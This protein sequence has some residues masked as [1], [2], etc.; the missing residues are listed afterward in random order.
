MAYRL[1]HNPGCS[2][3]RASLALLNDSGVDYEL[4]EYLKT[5]PSAAELQDIAA[6]LGLPVRELA[7]ASDAAKLG[8]T[9]ELAAASDDAA[10]QLLHDNPKLIERPIVVRD[11]GKAAI[12]RPT[13]A[14]AALL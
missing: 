14:V 7:R 1:Y 11:D 2:K 12:G 13:E 4:V 10:A 6:A 5:P 3:S 8:L 9:E